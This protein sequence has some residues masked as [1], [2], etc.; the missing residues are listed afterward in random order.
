MITYF[1]NWL[2]GISVKNNELAKG[3]YSTT[4]NLK[5]VNTVTPSSTLPTTTTTTATLAARGRFVNTVKGSS[6]ERAK[7]RGSG[8]GLWSVLFLFFCCWTHS[9]S[10]FK[11]PACRQ[12]PSQMWWPTK[13]LDPTAVNGPSYLHCKVVVSSDALFATTINACRRVEPPCSIAAPFR[14]RPKL[15]YCVSHGHHGQRHGWR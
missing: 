11:L 5:V 7:W 8:R 2:G 1:V 12:E 13:Q 9:R 15:D 14:H 6:L 4:S 3:G 10:I